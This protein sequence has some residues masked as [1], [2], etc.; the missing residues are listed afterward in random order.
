[1]KL[2]EKKSKS[3]SNLFAVTSRGQRRLDQIRSNL[4]SL[5]KHVDF[6]FTS[7]VLF[8]FTRG[9]QWVPPFEPV[10]G[11]FL[12]GLGKRWAKSESGQKW[13]LL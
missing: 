2:T 3:S 9:V 10:F 6:F 1:M 12:K 8:A 7:I 13:A 5:N 11:P 4:C